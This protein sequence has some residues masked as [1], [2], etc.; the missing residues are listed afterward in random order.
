MDCWS[1][2]PYRRNRR[3]HLCFVDTLLV[4]CSFLL[5]FLSLKVTA[6]NLD[7]KVRVRHSASVAVP[8]PSNAICDHVE[9]TQYMRLPVEQY[10]LVPMPLKSTLSRIPGTE[11]EFELVVPPVRFLWLELQ[12]VVHAVVNLE[13]DR[14]VIASAAASLLAPSLD[15]MHCQDPEH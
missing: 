12:P 5:I 1:Y 2:W 9:L 8:V 11:G 7:T 13:R 4:A 15:R 3:H 6:F 10:A 14:V